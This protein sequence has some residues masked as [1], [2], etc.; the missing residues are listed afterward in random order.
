MISFLRPYTTTSF[1][2]I[3]HP[4]LDRITTPQK[5][6]ELPQRIISLNEKRPFHELAEDG[7]YEA[8]KQPLSYVEVAQP[9][10][11]EAPFGEAFVTG[12]ASL[13]T[14][15]PSIH[16]QFYSSR[17]CT[18]WAA[19]DSVMNLSPFVR[20]LVADEESARKIASSGNIMT[21]PQGAKL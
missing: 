17:F 16:K 14:N 21:I 8:K 20:Y 19:A 3:R 11:I 4:F 1:P 15:N 7:S 12:V 9:T 5:K 10:V 6:T 18:L 13:F 2:I